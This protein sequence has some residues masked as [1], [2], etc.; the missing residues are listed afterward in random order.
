MQ[1]DDIDSLADCYDSMSAV[2]LKAKSK[3]VSCFARN[4]QH[5][6]H[7]HRKNVTILQV[8]LSFFATQDKYVK[9][10]FLCMAAVGRRQISQPA[11]VCK[12]TS[13]SQGS[14]H[15]SRCKTQQC[16]LSLAWLQIIESSNLSLRRAVSLAKKK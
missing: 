1:R 10:T 8:W 7:R 5:S 13:H 6:T 2:D 15:T 16:L 4:R 14:C 9:Q 12:G 3:L 11:A